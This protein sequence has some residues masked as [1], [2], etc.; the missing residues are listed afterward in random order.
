M[1]SIDERGSPERARVC[2]RLRARATSLKAESRY[3][4]R[5]V[6]GCRRNMLLAAWLQTTDPKHPIPIP[7][8]CPR[9]TTAR[10]ETLMSG[11]GAP[12]NCFVAQRAIIV[13]RAFLHS[14]GDPPQSSRH[15][16]KRHQ[17]TRD[18]KGLL[19]A[20]ACDPGCDKSTGHKGNDGTHTERQRH[21]PV[22]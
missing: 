17:A 14:R 21:P 12:T 2:Q 6:G 16:K 8:R 18:C 15:E 20:R 3:F 13:L 10:A 11:R 4:Y 9:P 22:E 7:Y 5:L 1:M 19:Q